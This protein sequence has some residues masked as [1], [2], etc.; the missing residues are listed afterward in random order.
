M[1]RLRIDI[2]GAGHISRT[3]LRAW[4][5]A[6]GCSPTAICD[7]DRA[8]ADACAATFAGLSVA[9][10]LGA[11][12]EVSDVVDVCTPPQ[13][14]GKI[15]L[16]VID[17]GRHLL[18]EKPVVTAVP[19]WQRLKSA[20]EES[21]GEICV[22]HN[23]KFSRGIQRA[24][25]WVAEGRIGRILRLQR[26]FLT[27]PQ[28]DRMLVA[29]RHWSHDLPGGRWFE[30][31]PHALYLTH[32]FVGPLELAHV[33]AL[34]T[35][36]APR[37]APVD[38]V[39]ISLCGRDCIASI[40]YSAHCLVNRRRLCLE[41]TE[42]VIEVDVLG[43]SAVLYR[44]RDARWKRPWTT[45]LRDSVAALTQWAPDRLAYL[46]DRVRGR[47]PHSRLIHDFALYLHGRGPHPT[48]IEEI[49]YVVDMSDRVGRAID[50]ARN[51]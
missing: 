1:S 50:A 46:A 12:I 25:R 31:L 32:A 22:M 28:A 19:D 21:V 42:G 14:H 40:D 20:I 33:T 24:L 48:P 37:G 8:A 10:D 45:G 38:E 43:D 18:I 6:P 49:D 5:Q 30:T 27:H 16:R 47:S 34:A 44:G 39:S 17:A 9:D 29:D 11:L 4:R 15:A 51:G 41:G 13:S 7:R 35:K 36:A 2:V 23:I 3:H 26:E